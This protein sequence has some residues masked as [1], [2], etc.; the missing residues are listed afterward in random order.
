[1]RSFPSALAAV[2]V[3]LALLAGCSGG[4][5]TASVAGD[6]TPNP[7]TPNPSTPNPSIPNPSTDVEPSAPPEP[8]PSSHS[9][10]CAR[11]TDRE[12]TRW[13][14][15]EPTRVTSTS[16]DRCSFET[17]EAVLHHHNVQWSLQPGQ[18][19]TYADLR[20]GLGLL[21]EGARTVRL[22]GGAEVLEARSPTAR[23]VVVLDF[24]DG[25]LLTVSASETFLAKPYRPLGEMVR[26][27]RTIAGRY[28][29]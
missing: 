26:I 7:S 20:E 14:G 11:V 16:P 23:M 28:A 19:G 25:G 1:M 15:G 6:P 10:D 3:G 18:A 27:A 22:P 5:D 17:V 24:V 4:D 29:A 8:S 9:L 13:V 12:A 21:G 2:A